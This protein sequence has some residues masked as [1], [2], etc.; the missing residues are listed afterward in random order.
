MYIQDLLY[1]GSEWYTFRTT[2]SFRSLSILFKKKEKAK[3]SAVGL[4]NLNHKLLGGNVTFLVT[5]SQHLTYVC[6]CRINFLA[7]IIHPWF[8]LNIDIW[9]EHPDNTSRQEW[10]LQWP[11]A[12]CGP[13]ECRQ[14]TVPI[15]TLLWDSCESNG[16]MTALSFL[17][18]RYVAEEVSTPAVNSGQDG[19]SLWLNWIEVELNEL[20]WSARR[21]RH[22]ACW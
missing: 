2:L 18:L 4:Q 8:N 6:N 13:T 3:L 9:L 14:G 12:A 1:W 5:I 16:R 19:K 22:S 20:Y 15:S 10:S 11:L 17:L 7:F 21:N